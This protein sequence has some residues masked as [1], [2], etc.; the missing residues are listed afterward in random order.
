M[1]SNG[2]SP[3]ECDETYAG[4]G[5]DSELEAQTLANVL[6]SIDN[7]ALYVTFHSYGQYILYPYGHTYD[8]PENWEDLENLGVAIS[9]AISAVNGTQYAVPIFL[10]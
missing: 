6:E 10:I 2:A 4:S 8:L 3:N 9:E 5:P 1:E 7:K